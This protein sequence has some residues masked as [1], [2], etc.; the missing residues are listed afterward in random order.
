MNI[1]AETAE[2]NKIVNL[3]SREEEYLAGSDY[4]RAVMRAIDIVEM[5]AHLGGSSV[6]ELA[7]RLRLEPSAVQ[8][9]LRTLAHREWVTK[10][11]KPATYRP[12]P[13]L[14]AM[15]RTLESETLIVRARRMMQEARQALQGMQVTFTFSERDK[16]N[17]Q[18][19]L[20]LH[21]DGRF[22]RMNVE[23]LPPYQKPSSLVYQA[24][25][26][27]AFNKAFRECWR[28]RDFN[29]GLWSDLTALD[30]FLEESRRLGVVVIDETDRFA[31]A[32][33]IFDARREVI[34]TLGAFAP[35]S[36]NHHR[37]LI[38]E[39]LKTAAERLYG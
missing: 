29:H 20:R 38:I 24:F 26:D 13:A 2:A 17:I 32:C 34:A 37:A 8:N 23:S 27:A 33:P 11:G 10:T 22:E 31:A 5:I 39:T 21:P 6:E 25:G 12:G 7:S 15:L 35:N 19:R 9:L 30:A 4:V 1:L 3:G 16:F 28:F 18:S 36:E 14:E